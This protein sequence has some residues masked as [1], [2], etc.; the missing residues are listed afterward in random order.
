M[1][2]VSMIHEILDIAN[3]VIGEPA[4]PDFSFSAKDGPEG[5]GVS[6]FDELDGMFERD[7]HR[8][9]QQKMDML[10]HKDEGVKLITAFTAV[11]IQ[12]L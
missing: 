5:M 2:V 11:S 8:G 10:G 4:L 9:S 12:G 3:P 6:A 7:V 1:N